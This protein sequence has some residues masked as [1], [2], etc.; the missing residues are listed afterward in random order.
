MSILGYP[1]AGRRLSRRIAAVALAGL[2]AAA[3][4]AGAI[5]PAPAFAAAGLPE[6][7]APAGEPD[8]RLLTQ[9]AAAVPEAVGVLPG[10][11][12]YRIKRWFEDLRL[13]LMRDVAKKAE[14][15][16]ILV[17]RRSAEARALVASGRAGMVGAVVAQQERLLQRAKDLLSSVKLNEKN[18]GAFAR[19][20]EAAGRAVSTLEQVASDLPQKA[21]RAVEEV[22]GRLAQEAKGFWEQLARKILERDDAGGDGQGKG[23]K[24]K[25]PNPR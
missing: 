22:A 9:N 2:V 21:R 18:Q 25:A 24:D 15:L 14:Y 1:G 11:F 20:E 3:V 5:V 12:R 23:Q 19:L 4:L 13:V 16:G 6:I 8:S 7:P 17:E 10:S